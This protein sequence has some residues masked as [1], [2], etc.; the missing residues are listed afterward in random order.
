[1]LIARSSSLPSSSAFFD[2]VALFAA[3]FPFRKILRGWALPAL[4]PRP[5]NGVYSP[6]H[7]ETVPKPLPPAPSPKRRGGADR[8]SPSPLRGGGRGEGLRTDSDTP[9]HN[10]AGKGS[11]GPN[12]KTLRRGGQ[13][14]PP[15]PRSLSAPGEA[16]AF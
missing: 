3:I 8:L 2:G 4:E 5:D 13:R 16:G 12:E 1:R 11:D 6:P 15:G 10:R 14:L 7:R 9:P